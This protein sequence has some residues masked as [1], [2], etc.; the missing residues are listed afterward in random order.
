MSGKKFNLLPGKYLI[1]IFLLAL[2]LRL[3]WSFLV[4]AIPTSDAA[5]YVSYA[6][7]II[8]DHSYNGYG[9][10]HSTYR[11]P[12]YPFFLAAI[13]ALFGD[14]NYVA[15]RI[16]Q[17]F[18]SALNVLLI[19]FIASQFFS[20]KVSTIAALIYVFYLENLFYAS[21]LLTEVLFTFSLLISI[22]FILY[23]FKKITKITWH[24]VPAGFFWGLATLIRPMVLTFPFI[25]F[26]LF[27]LGTRKTRYALKITSLIILLGLVLILPW[28][29]RNYLVSKSFVLV[30]T[31][32][33]VN[34]ML[35]NNPWSSGH[36]PWP[37]K[38]YLEERGAGGELF[39][40]NSPRGEAYRD[41]I[42]WRIGMNY[43]FSHPF[44]FINLAFQKIRAVFLSNTEIPTVSNYGH[45]SEEQL[46]RLVRLANIIYRFVLI[47]GILGLGLSFT[48]RKNYLSYFTIFFAIWYLGQI[49][50]FFGQQRFRYP[51]IPFFSIFSAYFLSKLWKKLLS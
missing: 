43:I 45:L 20:R 40:E 38:E 49:A 31:T 3:T 34:C 25:V 9:V 14:K 41:K 37:P 1:F 29:V 26:I 35:G 5:S 12:G 48:D 8:Q 13:F 10:T 30:S 6:R 24:L 22:F 28:S 27:C 18:L 16:I 4:P 11:P 47:T 36:G 21:I 32:G 39:E 15:V 23:H 42:Y 44:R 46:Y 19:Y 17:S 2:L 51:L 7:S 33:G 50:F